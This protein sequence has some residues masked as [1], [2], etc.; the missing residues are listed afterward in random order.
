MFLKT[1]KL[2]N[3]RQFEQLQ[4]SFSSGINVITGMNA[5]GKTSLLESIGYLGVTKSF[6]EA[7]DV[8]LIREGQNEMA[9]LGTVFAGEREKKLRILKQ[10]QGKSVF[11]NDFR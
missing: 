8:D 3:F 2:F 6:R 9:V 5:V 4:V 1:I 10:K 11:S 7:L